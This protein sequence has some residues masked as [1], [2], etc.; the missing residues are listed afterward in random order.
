MACGTSLTLPQALGRQA[1]NTTIWAIVTGRPVDAY[2]TSRRDES[3]QRIQ[4]RRRA[5]TWRICSG[6]PRSATGQVQAAV[7]PPLSVA[8]PWTSPPLFIQVRHGCAPGSLDLTLAR[9]FGQVCPLLRGV[10]VGLLAA[11]SARCRAMD[12]SSRSAGYQ[13]SLAASSARSRLSGVTGHLL[14][15]HVDTQ[16]AAPAEHLG[17]PGLSNA[18]S[19]LAYEAE[20]RR[21]WLPCPPRCF[22]CRRTT[23]RGRLRLSSTA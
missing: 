23:R 7:T 10:V 16:V 2:A 3:R 17:Q 14:A 9:K 21:R 5:A 18:V 6:L 8:P 1:L 20:A 15:V 11:A 22:D 12:S 4:N 13:P 19:V